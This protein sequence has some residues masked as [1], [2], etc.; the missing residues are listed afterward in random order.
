MELWIVGKYKSGEKLNVVWDF[1]GVFDTEEK[2]IEA[3]RDSSYFV[4]PA[5]LN[6]SLAGET[7]NWPNAYY[8]HSEKSKSIT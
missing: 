6:Q 1:N 4:A 8:P 2:A 3:C 5:I 7:M